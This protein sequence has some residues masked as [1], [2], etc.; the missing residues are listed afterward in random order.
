MTH[1]FKGCFNGPPDPD[2]PF[3]REFLPW[4][5]ESP[6]VSLISQYVGAKVLAQAGTIEKEFVLNLKGQA[7]Q[8]LNHKLTTELKPSME[9]LAGVSLFIVI[10]FFFGELEVLK[11]H[12]MGFKQI[13]QLLGGLPQHG[14]GALMARAAIVNDRI[15]AFAFEST[16]VLRRGPD[17]DFE[18]QDP[19]TGI[20]QINFNTPVCVSP[21]P[22]ELTAGALG[23]QHTTAAILDDLRFLIDKV[24]SLG[25]SNTAQEIQQVRSLASWIYQGICELPM[26]LYDTGIIDPELLGGTESYA[27]PLSLIPDHMSYSSRSSR[28]PDPH[29]SPTPPGASPVPTINSSPPP[30]DGDRGL[31][32]PYERPPPELMYALVRA[33]APIYARAIAMRQPLSVVCSEADALTVLTAAWHIPLTQWRA[34]VG[35]F[36]FAFEAILPTMHRTEDPALAPHASFVKGIVQAGHMQMSIE[37]WCVGC[38]VA[39]RTLRLWEWLREGGGPSETDMPRGSPSELMMDAFALWPGM[40]EEDKM[41]WQR[42]EPRPIGVYTP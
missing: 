2:N 42:P 15:V 8:A 39:Q 34:A 20:F 18:Y 3:V 22:F 12:L 40:Y 32:N 16:P 25:P 29:S 4:S 6:L 27:A 13:V 1:R 37:N 38:Q 11:L 19:P 28:S 35:V 41:D 24:L 26:G 30:T 7:I 21:Y 10:E 5:F 17:F 31:V 9:T 23:L 36:S 14:I 33:A